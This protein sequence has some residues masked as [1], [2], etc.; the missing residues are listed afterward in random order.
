MASSVV[1]GGG[2]YAFLL[3]AAGYALEL[4]LHEFGDPRRGAGS[5]AA[6][7]DNGDLA[8]D[9]FGKVLQ[10]PDATRVNV[11]ATATCR[12]D[13]DRVDDVGSP[14]TS[15]QFADPAGYLVFEDLWA[16]VAQGSGQLRLAPAIAPGLGGHDGRDS[17]HLSAID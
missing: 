14:G 4:L 15:T 10:V 2:G 13:H 9:V 6:N 3:L 8:A 12:L 16:T 11:I 5:S 17:R 1:G 7:R